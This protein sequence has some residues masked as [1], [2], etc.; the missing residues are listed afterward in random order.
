MAKQTIY[1]LIIVL[2][3]HA[4]LL[5]QRSESK[6]PSDGLVIAVRGARGDLGAQLSTQ[7]ISEETHERVG[8][9]EPLEPNSARRTPSPCG[10][11]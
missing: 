1:S 4:L 8:E 3:G 11:A 5:G 6:L 2:M 7:K 9:K 10:S